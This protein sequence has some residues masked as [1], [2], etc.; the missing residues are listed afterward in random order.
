MPVEISTKIA[1]TP[2]KGITEFVDFPE[3]EAA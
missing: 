2:Q 1:E 3:W